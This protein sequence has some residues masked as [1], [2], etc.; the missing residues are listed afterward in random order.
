MLS[1]E[2]KMT[3]ERTNLPESILGWQDKG[4]R[5][6]TWFHTETNGTSPAVTELQILAWFSY[7]RNIHSLFI[8]HEPQNWE[9]GKAWHNAGGTVQQTQVETV[10]ERKMKANEERMDGWMDGRTDGRTDRW[11]DG[12]IWMI[13]EV[14]EHLLGNMNSRPMN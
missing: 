2:K 6:I 9:N 12:Y 1:K 10:P 4:Q 11:M 3:G 8:G 7:F 13:V 14:H 5:I